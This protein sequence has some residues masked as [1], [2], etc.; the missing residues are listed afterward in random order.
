[1]R[2]VYLD[3]A[4]TTPLEP[5][6][7]KTMEVFH[8]EHYGNPESLHHFGDRAEEGLQQARKLIL[9]LLGAK[10]GKLIFT[11]G[12]TE[13]NNLALKGIAR[14]YQSEGRHIIVSAIEHDSVL[15]T[16][17]ALEQEGFRLTYL[18]VN[19]YGQV[20]VENVKQALTKETIIV[21]IMQANN[22]VGSIQ[23]IAEIGQLISS[24][25]QE[26]N[27]RFPLF[28]CDAIQT[29]GKQNISIEQLKV[30]LL[31]FSA[32]KFYGPKGVGGLYLN[33]RIQPDVL[34]H[35]GGQEYEWRS[36]TQN[37][38]G[39]V[40]AAYALKLAHDLL[41]QWNTH[42]EQ[43]NQK[44]R[45]ALTD[46][47]G[48][49]LTLPADKA[50]PTHIHFRSEKVEGQAIMQ[51][52]SRQGIAVSTSSA[53]HAK[54]WQPSHVML[55]MGFSEQQGHQGVRLTLGKNVS[56]GDVDYFIDHLKKILHTFH[57]NA[58]L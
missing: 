25:R 52:L 30:D 9:Q 7:L 6:I 39:I 49:T 33:K 16:C 42:Y 4:A 13:A 48:I 19:K 31:T 26:Q 20:Q 51:E 41:D 50:L 21:S 29:V 32:H 37:V 43:F 56:H 35:G 24:M 1:M 17:Q 36:G 8:M 27:K 57:S 3:Y 38:A 14:R 15:N 23:P 5:R 22:E 11:G 28:H 44:I 55:A 46:M 34:L 47:E 45:S 18:P 53:C 54:H 12:G 10:K 58:A 2:N 40:G